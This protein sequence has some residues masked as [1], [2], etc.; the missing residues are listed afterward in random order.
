[1][2]NPIRV[3]VSLT[4]PVQRI[5]DESSGSFFIFTELFVLLLSNFHTFAGI[6]DDIICT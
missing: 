5:P 4:A 1:M 3:Q 6:K 2:V